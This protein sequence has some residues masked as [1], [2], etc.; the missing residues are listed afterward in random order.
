V[1]YGGV[2]AWSCVLSTRVAP[3]TATLG[4]VGAL[5]LLL[6]LWRGLDDL[7]GSALLL[8]GGSYVLGLYASHRP[9]DEAAPLVAIALLA[10][11]ELAT[12]SL[13]ARQPIRGEAGLTLVRLRAVAVLVAAGAAAAALVVIAGGTNL[14]GGLAWAVLGVASAVGVVAIAARLSRT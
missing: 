7:L 11:G 9:L 13:E 1:L 3:V 8:V 5:L 6:V 4:G 14:G 2:L 12:W 10:C